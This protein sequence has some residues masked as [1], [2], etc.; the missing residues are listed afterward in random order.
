MVL[1]LILVLLVVVAALLVLGYRQVAA[2]VSTR[3]ANGVLMLTV[4]IGA[5]V[6]LLSHVSG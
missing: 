2:A 6:W 5:V 4:G 3:G 1:F